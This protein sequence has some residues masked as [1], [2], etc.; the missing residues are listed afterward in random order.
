MDSTISPQSKLRQLLVEY[1]HRALQSKPDQNYHCDQCAASFV[2][3]KQLK[4]HLF[5]NHLTEIQLKSNVPAHLNKMYS[6]KQFQCPY[7]KLILKT[8]YSLDNHLVVHFEGIS[9]LRYFHCQKCR[10]AFKTLSALQIH[11]KNVHSLAEYKCP[12]CSC[13]FTFK[14]KLTQ[15]LIT[16]TISKCFRCN[17]CLRTFK[18]KES[19]AY[20]LKG[21][22]FFNSFI[23]KPKPTTR[24]V[25]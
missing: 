12:H 1:K 7:C 4:G 11:N 19:V 15:H 16:H 3:S 20:H 13:A 23:V 21:K 10:A 24:K 17:H 8:K 18:H 2:S 14:S 22:H 25:Q 6:K 9:D 5:S